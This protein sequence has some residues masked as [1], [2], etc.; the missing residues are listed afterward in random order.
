MTIAKI[1]ELIYSTIN[2]CNPQ[3]ALTEASQALTTTIHEFQKSIIPYVPYIESNAL[4]ISGIL[5]SL[6]TVTEGDKSPINDPVLF[7]CIEKCVYKA[8]NPGGPLF[9]AL[10]S[11][12]ERD[13]FLLSPIKC[14]PYLQECYE[15][16]T[17]IK[18]GRMEMEL[19]SDI[20]ERRN[21]S[22]VYNFTG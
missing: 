8:C 9:L 11:F 20:M 2:V 1:G 3:A 4:L 13:E 6:F 14:T 22:S 17:G 16:C 12:S 21:Q 19:L 15:T 18:V 7:A 5:A 10:N